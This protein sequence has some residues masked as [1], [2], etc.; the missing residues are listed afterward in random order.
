[1]FVI[2]LV[3]ITPWWVSKLWDKLETHISSV[4]LVITM[5]ILL[6]MEV[7]LVLNVLGIE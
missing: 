4:P 3:I 6:L 2:I 5:G 1:M 7:A